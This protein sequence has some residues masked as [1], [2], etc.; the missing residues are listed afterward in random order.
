MECVGWGGQEGL[1]G[2]VCIEGECEETRVG[3]GAEGS[4]P[5]QE[6]RVGAG[7]GGGRQG[8]CGV[9]CRPIEKDTCGVGWAGEASCQRDVESVA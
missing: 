1:G 7:W 6:T 8:G 4:F 3:W 5:I 2:G 9:G